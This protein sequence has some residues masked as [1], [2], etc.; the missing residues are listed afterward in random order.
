M[1]T[2]QVLAAK[3]PLKPPPELLRPP[4][5]TITIMIIT[6]TG[7]TL[8]QPAMS[9]LTGHLPL[10]CAY[11]RPTSSRQF[12]PTLSTSSPMRAAPRSRTRLSDQFDS[13]FDDVVANAESNKNAR[14]LREKDSCSNCEMRDARD[15]AMSPH[16]RGSRGRK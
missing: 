10:L 3:P 8:Q 15:R 14:E 5:I 1:M 9:I 11:S 4:L 16:R 6:T 12:N 13:E 2:N 7:I